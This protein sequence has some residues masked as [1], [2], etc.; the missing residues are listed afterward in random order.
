MNKPVVGRRIYNHT[1]SS[2]LKRHPCKIMNS[3]CQEAL[4][5]R[6][7]RHP[8]TRLHSCHWWSYGSFVQAAAV[9]FWHQKLSSGCVDADNLAVKE[10]G[11][12][13]APLS[14]C[15][16]YSSGETSTAVG[17]S[18]YGGE[19]NMKFLAADCAQQWEEQLFCLCVVDGGHV[20]FF[21]FALI[22]FVFF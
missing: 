19:A 7:F 11:R 1:S 22:S 16:M 8:C 6:R 4:P 15:V 2:L 21:F 9:S 20:A 5:N 17:W 13:W 3:A 18:S 10:T 12:L 14:S